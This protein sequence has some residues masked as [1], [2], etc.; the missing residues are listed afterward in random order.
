TIES[1]E[2]GSINPHD[3]SFIIYTVKSGTRENRRNEFNLVNDFRKWL[4]KKH[5]ITSFKESKRVDIRFETNSGIL[6]GV[7]AKYF[8]GKMRFPIRSALGQ[9]IE[10]N[11]Y[12][13]RR[14]KDHWIILLNRRPEKEERKWVEKLKIGVPLSLCWRQDDG[15]S[16]ESNPLN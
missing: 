1:E 15:F 9:I 5:K 12:P 16:F 6:F 10:Y 13:G 11:F 3:T 4:K 14:P 2:D 7:E 8:D